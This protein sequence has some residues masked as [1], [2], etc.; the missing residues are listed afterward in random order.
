M[1]NALATSLRASLRIGKPSLLSRCD[2]RLLARRLRRECHQAGAARGDF[3]QRFLQGLQFEIAVRAPDAA[4]E[5]KHQWSARQQFARRNQPAV[6]IGQREFRR[7]IAGLFG[8]LRLPAFD[9]FGG[10]AAHGVQHFLGRLALPFAGDEIGFEGIEA[11]LQGRVLQSHWKS[12][13]VGWPAK[14]AH[15]P[16][17]GYTANTDMIYLYYK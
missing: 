13:S 11:V 12:P 17:K 2:L 4:I 8:A 6:G 10:G 15:L 9:Q 7:R 3:R 1:P 16:I 5:R 14:L